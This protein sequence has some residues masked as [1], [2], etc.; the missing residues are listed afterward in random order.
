MLRLPRRLL[1]RAVT[2]AHCSGESLS[3]RY[4]GDHLIIDYCSEDADGANLEE[5][6]ADGS[7]SAL[8][9]LRA[10]LASGDHRG[11]CFEE[12]QRASAIG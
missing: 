10:E 1:N 12:R 9:S 6:D 4:T 7:M 11:P 2:G 3:A 5:G 8:T